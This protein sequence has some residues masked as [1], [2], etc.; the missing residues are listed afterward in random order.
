MWAGIGI[1]T[2]GHELIPTMGCSISLLASFL[3]VSVSW[4]EAGQPVAPISL[5]PGFEHYVGAAGTMSLT[6]RRRFYSM[7][8]RWGAIEPSRCR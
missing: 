1:G 2:W 7:A 8:D 4:P 3:C 6:V 5:T